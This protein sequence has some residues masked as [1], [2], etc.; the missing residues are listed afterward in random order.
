V[1]DDFVQSLDPYRSEV[2]RQR[3]DEQLPQRVRRRNDYP[4]QP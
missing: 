1:L 2:G 4:D 3:A